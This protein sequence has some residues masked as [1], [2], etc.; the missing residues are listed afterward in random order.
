MFRMISTEDP[1]GAARLYEDRLKEAGKRTLVF[2]VENDSLDLLRNAD[3]AVT[4]DPIRYDDEGFSDKYYTKL[5]AEGLPDSNRAG[6]LLR[7]SSDILIRRS[8]GSHG[9]LYSIFSAFE[10]SVSASLHMK[11]MLRYLACSQFLR[12][13]LIL[14]A[15][16]AGNPV[17][18][19]PI[20]LISGLV[21]DVFTVLLIAYSRPTELPKPHPRP[22]MVYSVIAAILTGI[23]LYFFSM[24]PQYA[25]RTDAI[26]GQGFYLF[27]SVLLTQVCMFLV[28]YRI[29]CGKFRINALTGGF[30]MFFCTFI[31]RGVTL[32]PI[33]NFLGIGEMNLFRCAFLW[34]APLLFLLLSLL[35]QLIFLYHRKD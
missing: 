9:G 28:I 22:G 10:A 25:G 8:A 33:A 3:I 15:L 32:G 4:C 26:S 2:S 34:C 13:A 1:A 14:T 5:P 6:Q 29:F 16:F 23:A 31:A 24:I 12:A 21:V 17:V 27:L 19:A 30:L 35:L 11:A 7:T 18:S 20:I